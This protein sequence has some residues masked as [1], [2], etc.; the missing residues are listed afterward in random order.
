MIFET[1]G[2]TPSIAYEA[3][4]LLYCNV[5]AV[6]FLMYDMLIHLSDEVELMWK[7]RNT[8]V[9]FVYLYLRYY[10]ILV[11]GLLIL[12]GGTGGH[13]SDRT[14]L[15]W[16]IA[17]T[18]ISNSV[19]LVVETMLL[20]RVYAIY[21][22]SKIILC[23]LAT[24][25]LAE[26]LTVL[27]TTIKSFQTARVNLSLGCM[28]I[29]IPPLLTSAWAASLAFQTLVFGLTIARWLTHLRVTKQLGRRS[30][31]YIFMR[32]GLWAYSIM[33]VVFMLNLLLFR[34]KTSPLAAV[35]FR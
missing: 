31:M 30:I 20:I 21:G 4:V 11:I 32:D 22:K 33:L 6:A 12:H 25:S 34:L 27:I 23:I 17:E 10:G 24:A 15:N 9:K 18:V 5:A 7:A 35:F 1:G 8:W 14:C 29:Y 3:Q 2:I 19:V 28:L 26:S 13:M 16:F